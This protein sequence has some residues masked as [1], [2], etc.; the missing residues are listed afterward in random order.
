MF[1]SLATGPEQVHFVVATAI[2]GLRCTA[3]RRED[4]VVR[5]SWVLEVD[6]P[7]MKKPVNRKNGKNELTILTANRIT[8]PSGGIGW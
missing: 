3:W 5:P 8:F 2:F 4:S 7:M 6:G 1:D